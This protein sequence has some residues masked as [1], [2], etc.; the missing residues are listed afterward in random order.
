[1]YTFYLN[2]GMLKY[3]VLRLPCCGYCLML[4]IILKIYENTPAGFQRE[5]GFVKKYRINGNSA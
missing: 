2:G 4:H 5:I 3:V 1:M